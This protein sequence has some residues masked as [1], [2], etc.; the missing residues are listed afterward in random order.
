[1]RLLL[2]NKIDDIAEW[3]SA[4]PFEA[5]LFAQHGALAHV[6][7]VKEQSVAARC[8]LWISPVK[9]QAKRI[10]AVGHFAAREEKAAN[11][12]LNEACRW[13]LQQ[14][15]ELVVGP[16]DGNTWRNYRFVVEHGEQPP[17]FLEPQNL[18]C[19][20]RYFTDADFRPIA[21][22][23]SILCDDL[24]LARPQLAKVETRLQNE[25]VAIRALRLEN[26]NDELRHI[27]RVCLRSFAR[28]FLFEPVSEGELLQ[29]YEKIK[30]FVVPGLV[31]IAECGG[32]TVGFSFAIPD[33]L[34]MQRGDKMNT[35]VIKTIAILPER[36]L[37]GLGNF[38]AERTHRIAHEMGF[39][40]AIH[41]LI[42][43]DNVSRNTS[44]R[45][46]ET[47]RRYALF[48]R[49]LTL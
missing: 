18:T 11:R 26:W 39:H 24:K 12:V 30:D 25:G 46:G 33:V 4:L 32:E 13:L 36:R 23:S 8:S 2:L 7:A 22:Y 16:M 28:N 49:D 29:L 35:V 10:G 5:S 27:H 43:N 19:Y 48:V 31:S 34:Q 9:Y 20:P 47:M 17:F 6:V 15:C 40:R 38:L 44:T 1:M 41:A 37:A 45:Y 42:H 3:Q 21:N 14:G